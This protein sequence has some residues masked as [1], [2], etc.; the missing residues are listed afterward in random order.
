MARFAVLNKYS[1]PAKSIDDINFFT[2]NNVLEFLLKEIFP[3]LKEWSKRLQANPKQAIREIKIL[4][5]KLNT[6]IEVL[7][8]AV[9]ASK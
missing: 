5:A 3:Q 1:V 6:V 9:T 2:L 7:P 8:F 4:I